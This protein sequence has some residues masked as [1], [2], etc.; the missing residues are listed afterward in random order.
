MPEV[1]EQLLAVV[2]QLKADVIASMQQ[3]DRYVTGRTAEA[4]EVTD[5]GE[6]AAALWAPLYIDALEKGRGPTGTGVTKS[7]PDLYERIK[8]WCA[9]KGIDKR[10]AWPITQ[11]IHR[12]G[13]AGKPGVLTEPLSDENLNKRMQ[14]GLGTLAFLYAHELADS[15]KV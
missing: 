11:K 14:E 6:N 15:L 4:L 10:A 13:Y 12:E 3:H 7:D 5:I 1:Q 8:E 9:A 2:N